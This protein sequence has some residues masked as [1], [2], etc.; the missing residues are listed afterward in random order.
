MRTLLMTATG[1]VLAL[2]FDLVVAALRKRGI[3]RSTDGG[4]L[5]ICIWLAVAIVDFWFGVEAGNTV[6]LELGVHLLIFAVPA[7]LAWYLSRRRRAPAE[8]VRG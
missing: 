7:A 2:V 1:V 8:S 5:F 3:G 4:R 6:S